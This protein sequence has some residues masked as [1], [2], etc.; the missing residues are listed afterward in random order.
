MNARGLEEFKAKAQ[1]EAEKH[2]SEIERNI[3]QQN[4]RLEDEAGVQD[5]ELQYLED[6]NLKMH[7]EN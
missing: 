1:S 3:Q 4:Q 2:I 7:Q 6:R 5:N